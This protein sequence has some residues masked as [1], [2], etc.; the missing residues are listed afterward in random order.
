VR[1]KIVRPLERPLVVYAGAR[2]FILHPA[3]ARV[4]VDVDGMLAQALARSRH[5]NFLQRAWH[6]LRGHSVH[7]RV[8]LTIAH[9]WAPVTSFVLDV[10]RAVHRPPRNS[11]LIV[12]VAA[13]DTT[14]ARAGVELRVV[15]LL[16]AVDKAIAEPYGPRRFTASL[17][18]ILPRTTPRTLARRHPY[19]ITI[20]RNARQL[21]LFQN[22]RLSKTYPIAVGRIGLET[23]A[24]FY[25][26]EDKEINPAWHVPLSAWAGS[27]A[28]QTI[29]GG[30]S[31]NPLKARWMGFYNGEGIHGTSDISSLGTAASHGCIR[32][33]V[34]DVEELYS[35]VPLHTP[36]YIV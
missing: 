20:D 13:L 14:P 21:H 34:P 9:Q 27:L 26:I 7:L 24:G 19:F 5:G 25:R 11:R 36:I 6:R 12:S 10:A 33:S 35:I 1:A 22:L 32:M 8:P 29:P 31:N 4:H 28:G 15:P 17:E 23:A 16:S 2:R 3:A 30:A 18:P